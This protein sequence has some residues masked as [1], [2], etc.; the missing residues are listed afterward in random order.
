MEKKRFIKKWQKQENNE[1]KIEMKEKTNMRERR[2]KKRVWEK[3]L[4]EK[5]K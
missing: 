3:V 2:E 1:T 5:W 4:L